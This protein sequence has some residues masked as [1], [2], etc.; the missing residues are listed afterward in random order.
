MRTYSLPWHYNCFLANAEVIDPGSG[1]H[2]ILV[3]LSN[4]VPGQ[5]S[6]ASAVCLLITYRMLM[7]LRTFMSE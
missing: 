5:M 1:E 7:T 4:S 3:R 2:E 6:M